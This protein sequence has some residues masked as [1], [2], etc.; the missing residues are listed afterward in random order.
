MRQRVLGGKGE[1]CKPEARLP[2]FHDWA[3]VN[4]RR[5]SKE[6]VVNATVMR[7]AGG[8]F[9]ARNAKGHAPARFGCKKRGVAAAGVI[10]SWIWLLDGEARP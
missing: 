9:A 5:E 8:V 1:S 4:L 3:A 2:E 6:S 10:E 7:D